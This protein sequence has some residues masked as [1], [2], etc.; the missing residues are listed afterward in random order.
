[1]RKTFLHCLGDAFLT[2]FILAILLYFTSSWWNP[3]PSIDPAIA[4]L[5]EAKYTNIHFIGDRKGVCDPD[6]EFIEALIGLDA[7]P[8]IERKDSQGEHCFYGD[9]WLAKD[10][11]GRLETGN[12]YCGY[13]VKNRPPFK[14]CNIVDDASSDE[15]LMKSEMGP[16]HE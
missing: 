13:I 2:C 5:Q 14:F 4:A 8:K 3:S 12:I 15:Y 11:N 10:V 9:R 16:D 7:V 6:P 1:M